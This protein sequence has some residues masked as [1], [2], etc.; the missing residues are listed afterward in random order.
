MRVECG[1][2]AGKDNCGADRNEFCGGCA[3]CKDTCE[4]GKCAPSSHKG[5]TCSA[6]DVYWT[7]SCGNIE[8][9]KDDCMGLQVC[10]QEQCCLPATCDSLDVECGTW[11]NACG[12]YVACPACPAPYKC[13][14]G[15][16][17]KVTFVKWDA[18]GA[19]DGSSWKD[20]FKTIYEAAAVAQ[21][22]SEVWVAKGTYGGKAGELEAVKVGQ[23]VNMYGGFEGTEASLSDRKLGAATDTIVMGGDGMRGVSMAPG[24]GLDGFAITGGKNVGLGGGVAVTAGP[25][26]AAVSIANCT[27]KGNEAGTG[28]GIH[29]IDGTVAIDR[30]AIADNKAADGGGVYNQG[31]LLKLSNSVIS[32]NRAYG[33]QGGG[34]GVMNHQGDSEIANCVFAGNVAESAYGGALYN[35]YQT[36]HAVVNS[37]FALNSAALGGGAVFNNVQA[38]FDAA[39]CIFRENAPDEVRD[40]SGSGAVSKIRFSLISP[41]HAGE[42]NFEGDPKFAEP[43]KGD[44]H[45]LAGSPCID[46][47]DG[48]TAPRA[49]IEGTPRNDDLVTPD[50]GKGLPPYADVGAFEYVCKPVSRAESRCDQGNVYW[51]DSCGFREGVKEACQSGQVCV[52]DECCTPKSEAEICG[53]EGLACGEHAIRDNCGQDRVIRCGGCDNGRICC[54]GKCH[55][56]DC[57]GDADCPM[58][59]TTTD[60]GTTTTWKSTCY[61]NHCRTICNDVVPKCRSGETCCSKMDFCVDVGKVCCATENDCL[62]AA[63]GTCCAGVCNPPGQECK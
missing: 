12:G 9:K 23:D 26:G 22:G 30:C 60:G 21:L 14:Q 51:F 5:T 50:R 25:L 19:Q 1:Q 33:G 52:E 56:G 34:G 11:D 55:A 58:V 39:N 16:C 10:F 4:S 24:A 13:C 3:G 6:D 49:D 63:L 43:G 45:L 2:A 8:E 28:G 62:I 53:A 37:T 35:V 54:E 17:C 36:S 48:A 27:I 29:V 47:A 38:V 61:Q 20:A 15:Q 31:G 59:G 32:G 44:F 18:A 40:Y 41:L 42:G 57:C 7:D 46:A